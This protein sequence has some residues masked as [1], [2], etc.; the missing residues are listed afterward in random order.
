MF[1]N[2]ILYDPKVGELIQPRQYKKVPRM[3]LYIWETE[4]KK[5]IVSVARD[6]RTARRTVKNE[7]ALVDE[8]S[9]PATLRFS[10]SEQK[11]TSPEAYIVTL[12]V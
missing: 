2:V 9:G 5:L 10:L 12:G 3:K 7:L 4:N 1:H 11:Y 6:I 8:V